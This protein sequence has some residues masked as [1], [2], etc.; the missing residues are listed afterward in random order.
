M[1]ALVLCG[2]QPPGP[3]PG[4]PPQLGSGDSSIIPS[5]P[6]E[7]RGAGCGAKPR[8]PPPG[9][10]KT[11]HISTANSSGTVEIPSAEGRGIVEITRAYGPW[12]RKILPEWWA[13]RGPEWRPKAGT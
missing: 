6:A 3:V 1:A 10:G 2:G 12:N 5:H 11:T 13:S 7:P 8:N 4:V 9:C